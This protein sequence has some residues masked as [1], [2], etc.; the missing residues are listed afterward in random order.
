MTTEM[1]ERIGQAVEACEPEEA[2]SLTREALSQ[3]VDPFQILDTLTDV[4]RKVGDGFG[5]GD[6]FLP[7][8]IGA[9]DAMA[10]ATA[11]IES[12]PEFRA[13]SIISKGIVVIGTVY[14]DIHNIGKS[15]VATLLSAAGYQVHDLGVNV[16]AAQFVQAVKEHKAT[17]VG[18]SSLMTTTAMEQEKILEQLQQEGL[19]A[20]VKVI[21]GGG[22]VS[23]E[24]AEMI[25]ADG[26]APTAPG[27]VEL[28]ST[29]LGEKVE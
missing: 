17:V 23:R 6:L 19:R 1:L 8:L 3:D 7:D 9:A 26:Y 5:C 16:Q 28:V 15:L 12:Q 4:I 27:A 2:E 14:G 18:L 22:G 21:V 24:F 11:V 10:A 25:G 13:E 29:L 20:T